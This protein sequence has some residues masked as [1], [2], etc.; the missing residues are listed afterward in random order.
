MTITEIKGN[1]F[2][3]DSD[4]YLVHCIS[5]DFALGAG[6]AEQINRSYNMRNKLC[7][8]FPNLQ[9]SEY[10]I[11]RAILIDGVFNLITK[12]RYFDKP[13]YDTLQRALFDLK[14]QCITYGINKL[15]MPRIGCG[16]DRLKWQNVLEIIKNIFINTDVEIQIFSI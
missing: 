9:N 8:N 15:A 16:L 4:F 2:N 6:V 5:S 7:I 13:T 11:G 3:A 14:Y 10:A 12:S 1:L